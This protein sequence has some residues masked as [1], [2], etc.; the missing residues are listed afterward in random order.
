MRF[1]TGAAWWQG[2]AGF[3]PPFQLE[4]EARNPEL[5]EGEL[6]QGFS[7]HNRQLQVVPTVVPAKRFRG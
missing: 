1:S 3:A 6:E 2:R 4:R 7:L 5:V